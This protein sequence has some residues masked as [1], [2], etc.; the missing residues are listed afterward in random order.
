MIRNAT[1]S[2]SEP[3]AN[4]LWGIWHQFKVRQMPSPLHSY[5]SSEAVAEQIRSDLN[6]WLVCE[7][8]DPKE[9]GFFSLLP[10][11]HNKIYKK[12]RFPEQSIQIE[13]FACLSSDE[14]LLH[15]F[16]LLA[17]HLPQESILVCIP[18]LLRDAYWAALKSGFGVLGESPLIV[19]TYVWLYL[20][21]EQ[22]LDEI[23]T[24]LRRARLVVA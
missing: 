3:I 4:A 23:R 6:R 14:V 5:A 22:K 21:R 7:S 13:H 2:D 9:A 1:I 15:Q 10:I 20:D 12:W 8:T 11:G 17:A 16:Q 18:S 24:K 19:G